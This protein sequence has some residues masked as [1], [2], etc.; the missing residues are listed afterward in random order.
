M[1]KTENEPRHKLQTLGNC[2][3]SV[4]VHWSQP[5]TQPAGDVDDEGGCAYGVL[6]GGMCEISESALHFFCKLKTA[7]KKKSHNKKIICTWYEESNNQLVIG[8]SSE[9]PRI[10]S[11]NPTSRTGTMAL[12]CAKS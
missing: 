8:W 5:T 1:A 7:L 6:A 9:N 11:K 3:V 4:E 12:I 2:D 10:Q